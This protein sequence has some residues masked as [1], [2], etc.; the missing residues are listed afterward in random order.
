[1][2]HDRRLLVLA[3]DPALLERLKTELAGCDITVCSRVQC[4]V[5]LLATEHIDV[6]ITDLGLARGAAIAVL[7]WLR[8]RHSPIRVV[9][10]RRADRENLESEARG[11]GARV[12]VDRTASLRDAIGAAAP[13]TP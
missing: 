13:L 5:D 1:M 3:D 2:P 8:A 12:R 7:A 10:V 6:V 11:L 9:V 4:A